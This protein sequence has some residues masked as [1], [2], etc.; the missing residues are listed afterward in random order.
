MAGVANRDT[1]DELLVV[2]FGLHTCAM[3]PGV[4]DTARRNSLCR[5]TR[6]VVSAILT[7]I[8]FAWCKNIMYFAGKFVCT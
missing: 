3:L 7:Y 2:P 1:I 5:P 4:A 8:E 6:I